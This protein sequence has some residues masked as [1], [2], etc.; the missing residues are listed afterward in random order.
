MTAIAKFF[1]SLLGKAAIAAALAAVFIFGVTQCQN[2]RVAGK[3]AAISADQTEAMGA[4]AAD[5]IAAVGDVSERAA[6]S[7]DLTREN[8]DAISNA[9]GADAP[10]HP[11]VRDAGL[12]SMCQRAAYR[13]SQQCLQFTPA[14][15]VAG[16]G[17]RSPAP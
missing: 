9:E 14:R 6:D 12:S 16:S 2:A 17:A 11:A 4:S 3:K 13:D 7:D 15:A 8:A 10:V 5:A 1:G